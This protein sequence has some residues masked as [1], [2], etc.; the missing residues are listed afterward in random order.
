[1][2]GYELGSPTL[3]LSTQ[4]AAPMHTPEPPA[5]PSFVDWQ[6]P[7]HIEPARGLAI[8][9]DMGTSGAAGLH[10][11]CFQAD[12][13]I[14]IVDVLEAD[15]SAQCSEDQISMQPASASLPV[16]PC[17]DSS[18]QTELEITDMPEAQQFAS[19]NAGEGQSPL[20][21]RAALSSGTEAATQQPSSDAACSLSASD[22]PGIAQSPLLAGL[23][24]SSC[25]EEIG[26]AQFWSSPVDDISVICAPLDQDPALGA[27]SDAGALQDCRK[28]A[29]TSLQYHDTEARLGISISPRLAITDSGAAAQLEADCGYTE[30]GLQIGL[31]AHD[32][33]ARTGLHQLSE[34]PSTAPCEDIPAAFSG[35]KRYTSKQQRGYSKKAGRAGHARGAI[36]GQSTARKAR[37]DTVEKDHSA[38]VLAAILA[39]Q[40]AVSEHAA[41]II[42]LKE[43]S[44]AKGSEW[45]SG[46]S[47][48]VLPACLNAAEKE[49]SI[50]H[51]STQP[52][53]SKALQGSAA[54]DASD[55]CRANEVFQLDTPGEDDAAAAGAERPKHKHDS[56]D[57]GISA[58]RP[59]NTKLAARSQLKSSAAA[60][61]HLS[62]QKPQG[63]HTKQA[64]FGKMLQ[65]LQRGKKMQLKDSRK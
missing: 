51:Q 25:T 17:M 23:V 15:L 42:Q 43:E 28:D 40:M 53:L 54:L 7:C 63:Q 22:I 1:M 32:F 19:D 61:L 34:S 35:P 39:L 3:E 8:D 48:H 20:A 52:D 24:T 46:Q 16:P 57:A 62:S 49:E 55:E 38:E 45:S 10:S 37:T 2:S 30:A 50:Q 65:A 36:R 31:K 44:E 4:Q 47:E 27:G 58:Y 33:Q 64:P 60:A 13:C 29:C 26:A 12:A 59:S 56:A 14:S 18:Y 21:D 5:Q 9:S 11:A 41:A 6:Q